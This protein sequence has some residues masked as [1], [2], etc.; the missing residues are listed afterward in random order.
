MLDGLGQGVNVGLGRRVPEG[1]VLWAEGR[2]REGK[3]AGIVRARVATS[4]PCVCEAQVRLVCY[5]HVPRHATDPMLCVDTESHVQASN[6]LRIAAAMVNMFKMRRGEGRGEACTQLGQGSH[7]ACCP[8]RR[9][10]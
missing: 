7:T 5:H 6:Q 2:Y 4:I 10:G 1:V 9:R 8:Q 3:S